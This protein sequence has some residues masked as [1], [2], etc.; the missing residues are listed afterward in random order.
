MTSTARSGD[1]HSYGWINYDLIQSGRH[2]PQANLYGGEDRFWISPEGSQFSFFFPPGVPL[3]LAH[4]RCPEL[5]DTAAFPVTRQSPTS[6][7]VA[8]EGVLTNYQGHSF[9]MRMERT[10]TLLSSAEIRHALPADP[11]AELRVVAHESNNR[12]QNVG[13]QPWTASRGLPAIWMLGMNKPGPR[14]A[15]IIP[16]RPGPESEL[17]PKVTTDYFGPIDERR[18]R[19]DVERNLMIFSGDGNY[20]SKLGVSQRRAVDW[21]GSWDPDVGALTLVQFTL[22]PRSAHGYTQN[23]WRVLPD[24]YSGD[25]INC[26]NDG[27]NE[28]GGRLGPFYELETLSPALA[29]PP[30]GD[31]VHC[32]RTFHWEGPREAL[33]AWAQK[34]WQISLAELSLPNW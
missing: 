28:L 19:V 17:G 5:I 12:L 34:L 30:R 7:T 3:E 15:M 31:Y 25:V 32:H 1:G 8:R 13:E 9:A 11:P 10:V 23:L 33:E 2:D 22:P 24:P 21:L 14:A 18:L 29:L 20:R 16:F 6:L 26:Y 27:P 4:W